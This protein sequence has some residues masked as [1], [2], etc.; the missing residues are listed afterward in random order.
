MHAHFRKDYAGWL[1]RPYFKGRHQETHT[2]V[3]VD[4]ELW[5]AVR[6]PSELE[7]DSSKRIIWSDH[8][9]GRVLEQL[10][11]LSLMAEFEGYIKQAEMFF[12][13]AKVLSWESSPLNYYYSF[14]NLAK[15]LCVLRGALPP[16]DILEPRVIRHGVTARVVRVVEDSPD[17]WKLTTVGADDVF[18]L[19]YQIRLGHSIPPSTTFDA[20][21]LLGYLSSISWQL[22]ESG[23]APKVATFYC[24]WV[25]LFKGHE[26]WDVVGVPQGAVLDQL[27]PHFSQSYEELEFD[28]IKDHAFKFFNLHAFEASTFR[29]FQRRGPEV[30]PD[31]DR[32][33]TR[34]LQA[35]LEESL[36]N[37]ICENL[38]GSPPS[39]QAVP[40]RPD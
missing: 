22:G 6:R 13:G 7:R 39:I 12:R 17:I 31:P 33:P 18:P 37:A 2:H 9:K 1:V 35:K 28:S 25:S 27:W 23:Y 15:A 19:L 8:P 30:S 21:D 40:A 26:H 32:W 11:I 10:E 36:P 3:D 38:E 29:F 34:I 14:L 4:E 5:L 20:H 24:H 16:K